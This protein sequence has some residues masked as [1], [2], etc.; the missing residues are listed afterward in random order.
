MNCISWN[1]RGLGRPRAVLELT[2]M[3]KK[4]SPS[5]IFL[6][7]TRSK[8]STLKNLRSK[9]NLENVHIVPRHNTGGGLALYWKNGTDLHIIDSSPSHIDAVVNPGVDDAWW[10]TGFY[11][12]PVTV[13]REHSWILLKHLCLKMDL[14]WLCLGDFNE[15][16]KAE[17]KIGGA[18][19]RERQMTDFR[20][21]LDFCGL[22]DLGYV[23]SPYT[24][25]NNQFDGVVTWIRL[26]RGVATTA[27]TQ[28]FPSFRVH[29]IA[30]SLSDHCPL[31][32]CLDDENVRFYKKG[33]PFCFEAVWMTDDRCDGVI[34]N[35]WVG[36]TL[37]NPMERLVGK[38]DVCRSSLQT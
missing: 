6:M 4:Y 27:W 28:L 12:N 1:C 38:V 2:E 20:A 18:P 5:I 24:W 36:N 34:K 3:V 15:I 21:A 8:D 31:W 7:E 29:H 14:P 37:V 11:G 17:E 35:A 13:N 30:G 22:C 19:H 9:L 32:V 25:C 33:R 16:V 10:F 23:G 26:D